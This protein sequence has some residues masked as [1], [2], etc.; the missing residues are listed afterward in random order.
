MRSF[1]YKRKRQ[2]YCLYGLKYL[3]CISDNWILNYLDKITMI[4]SIFEL[5]GQFLSSENQNTFFL[6]V[7]EC[8]MYRFNTV[9]TCRTSCSG[10][11]Y[12]KLLTR[13]QSGSVHSHSFCYSDPEK[14][15][16]VCV[17]MA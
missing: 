17:R 2:I 1:Q 16:C 7:R 4:I 11:R 3:F 14:F 6:V 15:E 10:S 8:S 5:L 9:L 13:S 12:F